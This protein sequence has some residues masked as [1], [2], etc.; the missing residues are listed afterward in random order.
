[1]KD[2]YTWKGKVSC[3][4]VDKTLALNTKHI[5]T[6]VSCYLYNIVEE[7]ECCVDYGGEEITLRKNQLTFFT[8]NEIPLLKGASDDYK[9]ITLII[10]ADFITENIIIRKMLQTAF[11]S[12]IYIGSPTITVEDEKHLELIKND[13]RQIMQHIDSPH[14]Y[15]YQAIQGAYSSFLADLMAV[16]GYNIGNVKSTNRNYGIFISFTELLKNNFKE[17]HDISFYAQQLHISPRYLSMIVKKLTNNTV[18]Y[19]INKK[20]MLEACWLLKSSNISVQEI[21]DTLH[22]SDQSAFC[23]F[24]KRQVGKAPLAYRQK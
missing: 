9:A 24:F 20:L 17:H 14:Q 4:Y 12:S 13:M 23:K 21:S 2:E 11:Y 10:Q 8:P 15:T 22:F 16:L 7:G 6:S 19:F 18:V 3:Q 5:K 1:M